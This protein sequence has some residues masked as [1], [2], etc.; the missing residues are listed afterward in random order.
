VPY[1]DVSALEVR[2]PVPGFF[3]RFVHTDHMT[4]GYWEIRAGS[5]LPEHGHTHEQVTNLIEGR[6][7]FSLAGEIRVLEPGAVVVI[8]A[9]VPHGG[10][11]LEDCVIIDAFYP[12][13]Q[14]YR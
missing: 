11:A 5:S 4:L 9:D 6:F 14:D 3:G 1:F 2:E 12:V 13:R 7:E 8:P 10:T